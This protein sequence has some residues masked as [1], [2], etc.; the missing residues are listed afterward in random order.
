MRERGG[1]RFAM[2]K[3]N[4]HNEMIGSGGKLQKKSAGKILTAI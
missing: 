3:D 1:R 4:V 2:Q